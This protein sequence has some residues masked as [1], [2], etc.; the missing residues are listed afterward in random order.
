MRSRWR[1][2]LGVC[3]AGALATLPCRELWAQGAEELYRQALARYATARFDQAIKL[4]RRADGLATDP[5]LRGQIQLQLGVNHAVLGDGARARAAFERALGHDPTLDLDPASHKAEIVELL[6]GVR[7]EMR[8]ELVV[9]ADRPDAVVRVDGAEAGRTPFSARVGIGRH[10][11]ELRT[12][13]GRFGYRGEVVVRHKQRTT[14]EARLEQLHGLLTVTTTPDGAEVDVDGAVI[15]RTP[16][17]KAKVPAGSHRLTLRRPD[18]R[19]QVLDLDVAHDKE[20]VLARTLEAV[21]VQDREPAPGSAAKTPERPERT[22]PPP[23][24]WK[25]SA[26]WVLVGLGG[27]ALITGVALGLKANAIE[28]DL[29]DASSQGQPYP[30]WRDDESL[31]SSLETAEIATLAVGGAAVVGGAVLLLLDHK[32][33]GRR[34]SQ[35]SPGVA[36]GGASVTATWWF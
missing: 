14:L 3:L 21:P 25:R 12:T 18:Y 30:E 15:G 16:L 19:E 13:D 35:I 1:Q 17:L 36:V 20:R 4:L 8:G 24:R 28:S 32:D 27:A 7:R 33:S 9:T 5:G 23:S 26:G 31:G 10:E 34:R 22:E 29:Q 2:V 11:L 6:R